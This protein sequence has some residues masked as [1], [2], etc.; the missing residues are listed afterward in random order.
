MNSRPH[1]AYWSD[2]QSAVDQWAKQL[3]TRLSESEFDLSHDISE[4]LRVARLQATQ[5]FVLAQK[6]AAATPLPIFEKQ[7]ALNADF[8]GSF[9]Q[10]TASWLFK[11]AS[12]LPLVMLLVGL[13][14]VGELQ[15]H[16][17]AEELAEFDTDLLADELPLNAYVDP[18][19]AQYLKSNS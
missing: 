12:V 13:P 3:T 6:Q 10:N 7:L 16:Y 2:P 19:F 11:F 18:G 8:F 9:K 17:R 15:D 14:L 4:R 5:A 1:Q